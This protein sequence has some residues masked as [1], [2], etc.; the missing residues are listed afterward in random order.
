MD[1]MRLNIALLVSEFEDGYTRSL[2]EGAVSAA[3]ELDA[4][5]FIFPGRYLEALNYDLYRTKYDYHFNSLF[6]YAT[7][8]EYDVIL[9]SMGTIAGNVDLE[10]K[11]EFLRQFKGDNIITIS[12]KIEGYPSVCFDN[13]F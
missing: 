9:I 13:S 8:S 12:A 10:T 2:C 5:L 4:N 11:V 7:A 6:S 3:K 1:K